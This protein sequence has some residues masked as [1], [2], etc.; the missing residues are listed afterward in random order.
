MVGSQL[1]MKD[2]NIITLVNDSPV[3]RITSPLFGHM[4]H[5]SGHYHHIFHY[6]LIVF[7]VT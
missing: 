4:I 3:L 1:A 7:S 5:L 6:D 2:L